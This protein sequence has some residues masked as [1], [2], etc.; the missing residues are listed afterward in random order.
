[1]LAFRIITQANMIVL[2][3][4]RNAMAADISKGQ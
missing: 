3:G 4:S 2:D 1:M